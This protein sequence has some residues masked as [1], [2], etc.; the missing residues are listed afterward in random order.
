MLAISIA[1]ARRTNRIWVMPKILDERGVQLLWTILDL[2]A[3]ENELGVDVRE[4]NFPADP[5]TWK[6]PEEPFSPVARAAMDGTWKLYAQRDASA[7]DADG[8]WKDEILTWDLRKISLN[9][10]NPFDAYFALHSVLPELDQ[11]ELLLSGLPAGLD[12]FR[13][14]KAKYRKIANG[15]DLKTSPA[16]KEIFEVWNLLRWCKPANKDKMNPGDEHNTAGRTV[17]PWD[18][19]GRGEDETLAWMK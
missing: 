18:C 1:L 19:Y 3:V 17:A 2:K 15:V 4:T 7:L 6:S 10:T 8:S 5:R 12:L 9:G 13:P 14:L 16:E 11:A